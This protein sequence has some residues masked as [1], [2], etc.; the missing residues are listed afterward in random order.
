[1]CG[2]FKLNCADTRHSHWHISTGTLPPQT[3]THKAPRRHNTFQTHA[4]QVQP[5]SLSE[6][7]ISKQS[8]RSPFKA[9]TRSIQ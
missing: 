1:M 9:Y 6:R 7:H 2:I 4:R 3:R 8:V 5:A